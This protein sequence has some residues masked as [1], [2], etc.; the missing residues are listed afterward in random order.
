MR[1][2]RFTDV[3]TVAI[4][5]ESARNRVAEAGALEAPEPI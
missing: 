3:Q 1:G 4:L 5:R 2:S